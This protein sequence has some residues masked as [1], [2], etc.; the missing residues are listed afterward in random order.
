MEIEAFLKKESL[1]L[2]EI[3][4][5]YKMSVQ[6]KIKFR[7]RLIQQNPEKLE[8]TPNINNKQEHL[9]IILKIRGDQ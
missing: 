9:D 6:C 7:G 2:R 1:K 4:D 8:V 5:K 3:K